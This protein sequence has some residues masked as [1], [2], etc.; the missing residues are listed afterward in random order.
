MGE[1]HVPDSHDGPEM[2]VGAP[3]GQW[4]SSHIAHLRAQLGKRRTMPEN[5]FDQ[6]QAN[7]LSRVLHLIYVMASF[8]GPV[9][10]NKNWA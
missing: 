8:S 3:N 6:P 9:S 7:C 1:V 2:G 10:N 5:R 4:N